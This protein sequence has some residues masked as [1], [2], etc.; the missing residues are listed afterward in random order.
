MLTDF[1]STIPRTSASWKYYVFT[2]EVDYR[3]AW[4]RVGFKPNHYNFGGHFGHVKMKN[5]AGSET[6]VF[7]NGQCSFFDT[8]I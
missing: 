3:V 8:G 4:L 6:F 1:W 7:T 5:K 2:F